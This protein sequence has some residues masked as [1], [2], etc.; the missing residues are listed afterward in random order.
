VV[1]MKRRLLIAAAGGVAIPALLIFI[2][3]CLGD[4]AFGRPLVQFLLTVAL[5]PLSIL[6]PL[7]PDSEN[8]TQLAKAVRIGL[9][10]LVV[11]A[12]FVSYAA[13]THFFFDLLSRRRRF[14]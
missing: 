4:E 12:D 1:C 8:L 10:L 7:I 2:A 5:W 13:L 11:I 9:F 3:G 14:P 6:G